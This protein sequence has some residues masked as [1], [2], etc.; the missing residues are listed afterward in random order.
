[1]TPTVLTGSLTGSDISTMHQPSIQITPASGAP[2]DA[3][4]N[5]HESRTTVSSRTTSRR[6]RVR[7]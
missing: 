3:G 7:R 4:V 6:P 5:V 1:M 2:S